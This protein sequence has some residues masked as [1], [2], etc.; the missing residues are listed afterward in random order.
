MSIKLLSVSA[1]T[2]CAVLFAATGGAQEVNDGSETGNSSEQ[3]SEQYNKPDTDSNGYINRDETQAEPAAA[4][5]SE[6]ADTNGDG[7]SSMD[8]SSTKDSGSEQ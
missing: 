3:S 8:D 1:L 2:F 4:D 5:T 6:G 7:K